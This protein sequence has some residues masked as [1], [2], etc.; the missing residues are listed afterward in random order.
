MIVSLLDVCEPLTPRNG[1]GLCGL[2][3]VIYRKWLSCHKELQN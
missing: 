3:W 1:T 2:P